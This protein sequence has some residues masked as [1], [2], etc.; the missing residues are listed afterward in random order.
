MTPDQYE[1]E[2]TALCTV[3]ITAAVHPYSN[4]K[5]VRQTVQTV[6]MIAAA[7]RKDAFHI[8]RSIDIRFNV[9]K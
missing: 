8:T 2:R 4:E 5:D 9:S 1:K 7:I 6:R 3:R